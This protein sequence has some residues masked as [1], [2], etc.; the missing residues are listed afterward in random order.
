MAK[1]DK[2]LK[3]G[4]LT[5]LGG[6]MGQLKI[7]L[8]DYETAEEWEEWFEKVCDDHIV[9]SGKYGWEIVPDKDK[10]FKNMGYVDDEEEDDLD[11]ETPFEQ[12]FQDFF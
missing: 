2:F 10:F 5:L 7:D 9:K 8:P 1:P 4:E 11:A 12:Y 6:I 3:E